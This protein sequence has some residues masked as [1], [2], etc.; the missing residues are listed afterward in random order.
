MLRLAQEPRDGSWISPQGLVGYL[1]PFFMTLCRSC[2]DGSVSKIRAGAPGGA[3]ANDPR[4]SSFAANSVYCVRASQEHSLVRL[5]SKNH[6]TNE[7]LWLVAT[8]SIKKG[9]EIFVSYGEDYWVVQEY[10]A[11]RKEARI[12]SGRLQ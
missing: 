7:R 9:S 5:G 1:Y 10:N 4:G 8:H 6:P 12:A 3:F 11:Q 2:I